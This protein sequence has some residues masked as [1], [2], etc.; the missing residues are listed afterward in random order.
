MTSGGKLRS[1][2]GTE[3]MEGIRS[4]RT[5]GASKDE[6]LSLTQKGGWGAPTVLRLS[7]SGLWKVS[8]KWLEKAGRAY[9]TNAYSVS[10]TCAVVGGKNGGRKDWDKEQP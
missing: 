9:E 4:H 2:V 1:K 8:R 3:T 5:T 6:K 10:S 7:I